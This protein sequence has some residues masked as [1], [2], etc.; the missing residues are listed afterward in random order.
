M[1]HIMQINNMTLAH[2]RKCFRII[3][4]TPGQMLLHLLQRICEGHLWSRDQLHIGVVLISLEIN[5]MAQLYAI[6]FVSIIKVYMLGHLT[7][8]GVDSPDKF[9]KFNNV[10]AL[11]HVKRPTVSGE[12]FMVCGS[13]RPLGLQ[14]VLIAIGL[15]LV[16]VYAFELNSH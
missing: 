5:D 6:K 15:V 11:K 9:T 16:E 8:I 3:T 14:S 1:I 10:V 2:T 4:K 7:M 13:V 12:A